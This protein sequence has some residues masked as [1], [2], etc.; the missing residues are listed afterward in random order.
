MLIEKIGN[1]A[2]LHLLHVSTSLKRSFKGKRTRFINSLIPV[3]SVSTKSI[4][5]P[6][7]LK[8]S[9]TRR[10]PRKLIFQEVEYADFTGNDTVSIFNNIPEKNC[11]VGNTFIRYDD[12]NVLCR[13]ITNKHH[14][15]EV[16]ESNKIDH[17]L[18]VKLFSTRFSGPIPQWFCYGHNCK[19][20]KRVSLSIFYHISTIKERNF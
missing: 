10:S 16:T 13:Q 3:P 11:P 5:S 14:I 15:P 17:E 9:S 8:I 1:Q 2:F 7:L 12:Q 6:A 19:L 20:K 18:H 4:Q